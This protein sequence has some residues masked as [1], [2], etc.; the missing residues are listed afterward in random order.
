MFSRAM[1]ILGAFDRT[2]QTQEEDE[3]F[4]YGADHLDDDSV[5]WSYLGCLDAFKDCLLEDDKQLDKD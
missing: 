4:M 5:G 1:M 2:P 3:T